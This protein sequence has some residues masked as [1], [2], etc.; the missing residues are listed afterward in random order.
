MGISINYPQVIQHRKYIRNGMYPSTAFYAQ[1]ATAENHIVGFR[2]KQVFGISAIPA[3]A[4]KDVSLRWCCHTGYGTTRLVAYGVAGRPDSGATDPTVTISVTI[5][6]GATTTFDPVVRAAGPAGTPTDAPS[7]LMPFRAEC[8]V[9]AN[10]TYEGLIVG[11]D[12][13]RI[14]S[15]C[16]FEESDGYI[17]EAVDYYNGMTPAS[18]MKIYDSHRSDLLPGLSNMWRRNGALQLNWSRADGASRTRTS[19]TAI[20]LIDNTE[21]TTPTADSAGWTLDGAYRT[22]STRAVIP[23]V[24]AAYGS[25]ASGTGRV[26]LIDTSG[27]TVGNLAINSATPGWF[28]ANDNLIAAGT[29]LYAPQFYGDGTNELSISSLSVMEYEA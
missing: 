12:G 27:N 25:M 13:A 5:P 24:I 18:G 26:R 16:I 19:A 10:Q 17:D 20:N 21:T 29:K 22:T 23:V 15:L 2:K 3:T 4:V 14:V 11:A 1:A 7:E 9:D 8:E 28:T 6:G